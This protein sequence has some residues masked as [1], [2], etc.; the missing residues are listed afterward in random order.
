MADIEKVVKDSEKKILRDV[1]LFDVYEGDKL[2]EGKKSYAITVTLRDDEKTLQDKYIDNVMNR[3][4]A[5]LRNRLGAEL[6]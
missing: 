2:P 3:I 4:I 1:T 6:R 5:N